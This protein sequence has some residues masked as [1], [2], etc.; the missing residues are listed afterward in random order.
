MEE[1]TDISS[2]REFENYARDVMSKL[3][4]TKLVESEPKGVPKKFDMVSMDE[5]IVGDAEYLT[6]VNKERV[7]PAKIMEISGHVWLLEKVKAERRF[8]VFGNQKQVPELWLKK[9]G[10]LL[11]NIEFYFLDNEGNIE[12]LN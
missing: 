1:N 12:R 6:L 5:K 2:W 8:L 11:K 9:Y 3:F 10:N 4:G 7:P